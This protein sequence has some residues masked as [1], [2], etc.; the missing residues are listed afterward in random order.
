MPAYTWETLRAATLAR[1]FPPTAGR[2]VA[3]LVGL[4]T[5]LGP[6]QSQSPRAP[7]LCL[8]ARMPGIRRETIEAAYES[9]ALIRAT[10]LRSTVH[11]CVAEHQRYV[12]AVARRTVAALDKR[13]FKIDDALLDLMRREIE[14]FC[15]DGWQPSGPLDA[16]ML[17]WLGIHASPPSEHARQA[18]VALLRGHP[19]LIRRPLSGGWHQQAAWGYRAGASVLR[20][21]PMLA[22]DG[23]L[24]LTEIH[25]GAYG[26][27]TRADLAWWT[28][29]GL[30]RIDAAV[31]ALGDRI[32][33]RPG[34]RGAYLDLAVRP[35]RDDYGRGDPAIRLLPEYDGLLL[36][37]APAGRERFAAA[38]DLARIWSTA[39][40]VFS[41]AL[42]VDGMLRGTWKLVKDQSGF[43]LD[44][45]V[46]ANHRRPDLDEFTPQ[47]DAVSAALGIVVNEV[48]LVSIR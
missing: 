2:D 44:V 41:P 30:R 15:A 34:P 20:H 36:G 37:Y 39:N 46:L 42:L 14:A 27:A 33:S 25:L 6:I 12:E 11:T 43:I 48:R 16:H 35:T 18:A 40:A 19:G 13:I 29:E 10:S 28:G 38:A 3:S 8:S 5:R 22:D 4:V 32:E 45:T 1:Q 26:P 31:T 7:F 17:S 47:V 9:H 24:A 23:L 21:E